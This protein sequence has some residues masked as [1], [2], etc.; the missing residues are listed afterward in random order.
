MIIKEVRRQKSASDFGRLAMY[1]LA[2]KDKRHE[3]LWRPTVSYMLGEVQTV[4]TDEKV[5]WFRLSNVVA[6]VA[7]MAI[8][9]VEATQLRNTRSQSDK[10]YHFVISFREEER[11]S[12]HVVE[13][14]EER[15][16]HALGFAE[17]QR[18]SAFHVDTDNW[19]LHVAVNKIHPETLR[20][21]EPYYSHY[22]MDEVARELELDFGLEQDNRIERGLATERDNAIDTDRD[23]DSDTGGVSDRERFHAEQG[24]LEWMKETVRPVLNQT[25]TQ[26]STS[27]ERVHETLADFG[28]TLRPHGAGLVFA[29]EDGLHWVKASSVARDFSK[30]SLERSLGAFV[31][32]D[33]E[34]QVVLVRSSQNSFQR[35]PQQRHPESRV[36]YARYQEER[37]QALVARKD[38][39][40]KAKERFE[41]DKA[42]LKQWGQQ[43]W[44]AVLE[45]KGLSVGQRRQA[46]QA[47]AKER[48]EAFEVL[49]E[50]RTAQRQRIRE[51]HALESWPEWLQSK[52]ERGDETAL[53]LLRLRQ[54]RQRSASEQLLTAENVE[55]A[56]HVV[57]PFREPKA[58]ANGDM[59]YTL[60]DGGVVVDQLCVVSVT[61]ETAGAAFFAA[62]LAQ[63][64]FQGQALVIEGADSFKEAVVEQVVAK[65]MAV[66]FSDEALEQHRQALVEQK[67]RSLGEKALERL[68]DEKQA[69]RSQEPNAV[70]RW[71]FAQDEGK[72]FRLEAVHEPSEGIVI[73]EFSQ[74][75]HRVLKALELE[76]Q[77]RCRFWRIGQEVV[78]EQERGFSDYLER[79]LGIGD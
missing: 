21:V 32:R 44:Q 52:A 60:A 67:Q 75:I 61:K 62:A 7:G 41:S 76:E 66:T 77:T 5:A 53:E 40:A 69:E 46:Y 11:P 18:I 64:R 20:T 24:F 14:I 73:A 55:A 45:N 27:W 74:G 38:E 28:V 16:C 31:A 49:R 59:V 48:A 1:L 63:E 51:T 19:H 35:G 8:A 65:G 78:Y 34:K 22:R 2:A 6:D 39:L 30:G 17:H 26:D 42:A 43:A 47:I 13:A 54:E 9:E 56:R 12:R 23:T 70:R 10:T 79:D 58:R 68:L 33:S 72:T 15:V 3:R 36:Y 29:L 50:G 25:L 71:D 4:E 37:N 57:F